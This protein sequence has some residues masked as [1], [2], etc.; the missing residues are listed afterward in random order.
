[1]K[2]EYKNDKKKR[3]IF[4]TVV[5]ILAVLALAIFFTHHYQ[6]WPFAKQAAEEVRQ[7]NIDATNNQTKTNVKP[8]IGVDSTKN[9]SEVPV[10][11]TTSLTIT[12]L[13]QTGQTITYSADITNPS[14]NGVCN[15]SFTKEASLP[16][17]RNDEPTNSKCGPISI[18]ANTFDSLGE[19]TLTL[20]YFADNTQAV[21]TA[22]IEIK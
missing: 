15:A 19:W 2:I 12:D 14:A 13:S 5:S 16:V 6:V 7:N 21:A 8:I 22:K 9:N 18:S 11:D 4:L 17:V 3:T 10:S 1:M 20:R